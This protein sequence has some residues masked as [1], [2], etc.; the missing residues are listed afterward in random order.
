MEKQ[1]YEKAEKSYLDAM[2]INPEKSL[3]VYKGC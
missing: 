2:D 3:S 1:N